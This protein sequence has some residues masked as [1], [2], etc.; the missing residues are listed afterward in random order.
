[1]SGTPVRSRWY[2]WGWFFF[3]LTGVGLVVLMILGF[4]KFILWMERRR[5]ESRGTSTEWLYRSVIPSLDEHV[6]GRGSDVG[7]T[8]STR[9]DQP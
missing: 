4:C 9:Q 5:V 7:S 2:F 8:Q 3:A 6:H 1:M